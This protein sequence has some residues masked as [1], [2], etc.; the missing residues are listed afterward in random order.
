L[1]RARAPRAFRARLRSSAEQGDEQLE[2]DLTDRAAVRVAVSGTDA[3]VHLGAYPNDADFD[4]LLG[5]NV[6]GLYNVLDAAR[7]ENVKRVVLAST[8]QVVSGRPKDRLPVPT[9]VA[10]PTNHYALTK[11]W[12]EA[13]GEMYSRC[14]GM[15]VIAIRIAWMVRDRVEAERIERHGGQDHYLSRGDVSRCFAQAV[16]APPLPF[17]VVYAVGPSGGRVFDLEPARQALGFEPLDVWP[18]GFEVK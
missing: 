16:E 4:T 18:N 10:Y 12:A 9:S 1:R 8:V 5:P 15:S 2:G 7:H 17:T 6:L 3:V 13:A 11:V 14:F